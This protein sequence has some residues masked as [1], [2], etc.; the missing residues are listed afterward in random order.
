LIVKEVR[1]A[2][3]EVLDGASGVSVDAIFEIVRAQREY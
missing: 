2:I 1:T 3:A